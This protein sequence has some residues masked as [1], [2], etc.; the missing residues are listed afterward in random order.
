M[1]III[2]DMQEYRLCRPVG[3]TVIIPLTDVERNFW[4]KTYCLYIYTHSIQFMFLCFRFSKREIEY[5]IRFAESFKGNDFPNRDPDTGSLTMTGYIPLV[6][7][8]AKYGWTFV[9]VF[10]AMQSALRMLTS[11]SMIFTTWYPFDASVS[12]LYELIN[13]SQVHCRILSILCVESWVTQ[14]F[15]CIVYESAEVNL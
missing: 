2:R 5:L 3:W 15:T 13:L 8:L 14:I 10:H 6:N 1:D 12:P 9:A 7:N 11:H 4:S